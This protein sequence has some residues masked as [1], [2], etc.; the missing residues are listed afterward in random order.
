MRPDYVEIQQFQ[1]E[2]I[3]EG[4]DRYLIP[5]IHSLIVGSVRWLHRTQKSPK[6]QLETGMPQGTILLWSC[7]LDPPPQCHVCDIH[8]PQLHRNQSLHIWS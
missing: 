8:C 1:L 5:S 2:P 4:D 7:G 3:G 6:A